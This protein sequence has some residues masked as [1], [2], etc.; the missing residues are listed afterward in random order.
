MKI[1]IAGDFCQRYRTDDIIRAGQ[2]DRL[3]SE[4]KP[5]IEE[6]DYSIVNF[7]FPVIK[8]GHIAHPIRKCGPNLEGTVEA[9]D[10][11]KY[12]GFKCCSLANNHIL[13]QGDECCLDTIEELHKKQIDTVGAGK[14]LNDA[15]AVL[16]KTINKKTI[17]IINCCE[18]EF[19]IATNESP[20]AYP[21]D[22]VLQFNQIKN[23][24]TKSDYVIVI[25]HGGPE[26]YQLPT[27]RMQSVY[28]Y[29]VEIGADVV[30]NHH[31]HCFCGYEIYKNAPI[32][33]GLGNL[34]FDN[35]SE[36]N[37]TWNEGYMVELNIDEETDKISYKLIPYKQC[38][39][40]V[41]VHLIKGSDNFYKKIEELNAIIDNDFELQKKT[42]EYYD[43][44]SDF[45]FNYWRYYEHNF[46]NKLCS[47]K[48]ISPQFSTTKLYSFWNIIECEAHRDKVYYAFR[49]FLGR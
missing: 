36:R 3:F 2:Y 44:C 16:Y 43:S 47:K 22:P 8:A 18:H 1:L 20:G 34:C 26:F 21:L 40:I 38:D 5:I 31:Q 10:A 45:Y 6:A 28:R 11:V 33:Y 17:A 7:E 46:M 14:N 24:K 19:T 41:G 15:K 12:A 30:I 25:V 23:A 32:F 37:G 13:D 42:K 29:F 4:V 35:P 9:V 39:E 49:K 27:P 48:W